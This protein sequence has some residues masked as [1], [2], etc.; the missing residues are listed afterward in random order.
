MNYSQ[1]GWYFITICSHH[2][3]LLF[4]DVV[5]D[6]IVLNKMGKIVFSEWI[7][8]AVIRREIELDEFVIMPNHLY[9]IIKIVDYNRCRSNRPIAPT[10]K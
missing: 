7:K 3:E 4:G 10:T 8:Q 6:K 1:D 9:G 2:H 5:N